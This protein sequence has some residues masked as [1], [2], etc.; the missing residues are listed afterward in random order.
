MSLPGTLDASVVFHLDSGLPRTQTLGLG[1][2]CHIK[3][4]PQLPT[5]QQPK[6]GH[7]PHWVEA[8]GARALSKPSNSQGPQGWHLPCLDSHM[9]TLTCTGTPSGK[10]PPYQEGKEPPLHAQQMQMGEQT[11]ELWGGRVNLRRRPVPS[12]GHQVQVTGLQGSLTRQ[13][14]H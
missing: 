9:H 13:R 11:P 1:I 10:R 14:T 6:E 7:T 8:Q 5:S 4:I 3:C 12:Q 2:L